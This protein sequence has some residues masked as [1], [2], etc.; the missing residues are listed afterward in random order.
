MPD[1]FAPPQSFAASDFVVRAYRPGDGAALQRATNES[2]DHLKPWMPW[3]RYDQTVEEAEAL[4]CKFAAAYQANED[5]ALGI[6]R[7]DKLIGGT[8]FHLRWGPIELGVIEIGMWIA[9]SE[10]GKGVGTAALRAMLQWGFSE[11]PW[12]RIVWKCDPLN[13]ASARVAENCG[14]QFEGRL[15]KA[16]V[17]VDGERHDFSIFAI[18][19]DEWPGRGSKLGVRP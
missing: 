13:V 19:K 10:A 16:F 8:G 6:W 3:A 5:Y 1:S 18:L 2:Y 11:W 12:Q 7:G 9:G 4:A 14:L 15:R 17:A